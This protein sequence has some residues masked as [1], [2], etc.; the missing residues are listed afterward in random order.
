MFNEWKSMEMQNVRGGAHRN[1]VGYPFLHGYPLTLPP[2]GGMF[3]VGT[4][5]NQ[6]PITVVHLGVRWGMVV[7]PRYVHRMVVLYTGVHL[8]YL[9]GVTPPRTGG[10][11]GYSTPQPHPNQPHHNQQCYQH[12]CTP[13][14]CSVRVG[15]TRCGLPPVYVT[16]VS[17]PVVPTPWVGGVGWGVVYPTHL[18]LGTVVLVYGWCST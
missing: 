5:C 6:H 13:Y 1:P 16:G 17:T 7:Q 3:G 9:W 14:G 18:P 15:V 12:V 10:T 2:V 11:G 8:T 4:G